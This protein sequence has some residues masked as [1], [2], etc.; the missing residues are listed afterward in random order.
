MPEIK[1]VVCDFNNLY[2]SLQTCCNGVKW[3]DG[4]AKIYNN[5]LVST[6]N[7]WK[8]LQDGTH[9]IDP[10][11]RFI[12]HEPKTRV[13][14]STQ[15]KDRIVEKSFCD[16]YYIG[17]VTKS[18]IYDNGACQKGKGTDFARE[19]LDRQLHEYYKKH[20]SDGYVLQLDIKDFFGSTHH[21][22]LKSTLSQYIDDEWAKDFLFAIIDSYSLP[23]AE[24]QMGIGLG[25][26]TNQYSQLTL[27]N[28]IDHLTRERLHISVY[29]RYMD[30]MI[31]VHPSKDHLSK[32]LGALKDSLQ[33]KRLFLNERKTQIYPLSQGIP[34][35]GFVF[36]LTDSGKVLWRVSEA[37]IK[38]RKRKIRG[39]ARLLAEGKITEE[40]IETSMKSWFSHIAKGDSYAVRTQMIEYCILKLGRAYGVRKSNNRRVA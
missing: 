22:V 28:E 24:V 15:P 12:I 17:Q 29:D 4:M 34:F 30:D 37:N 14:T 18:F 21:D 25:S 27:L 32:V 19:R 31:I 1:D 3:K 7:I 20:G 38:R 6:Y 35:L 40:T 13:V 2:D 39:F 8:P 16:N 5:A 9:S 33:D 11:N 36:T 23:D 10:Y 26:E